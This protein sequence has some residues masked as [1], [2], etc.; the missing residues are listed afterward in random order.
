MVLR[1][2]AIVW[3]ESLQEDNYDL[4]DWDIVK[5][6]F[7]KMYMPKYSARSSCANF[8]DLV[9]KS[10]ESINA[11]HV[12]IQM[13]YNRLYDSKPATMAT[14]KNAAATVAKAKKE[15]M[16]DMAKFFKHQLFLAS[17]NYNIRDKVLETKKDTFTQ[18]L[19]LA[20]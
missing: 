6:E 10:G 18:S 8:T 9:Q 11:N 14:E 5:R 2:A 12:C 16:N 13:A 3:W 19:K 20:H 1:D 7:L 4:N 15:G 17:I